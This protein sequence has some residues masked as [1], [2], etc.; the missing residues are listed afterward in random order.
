MAYVNAYVDN[1]IPVV[2]SGIGSNI[3]QTDHNWTYHCG[4][5]HY[6]EDKPTHRHLRKNIQVLNKKRNTFF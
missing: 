1:P 6:E 5:L 2:V 4:A 3:K